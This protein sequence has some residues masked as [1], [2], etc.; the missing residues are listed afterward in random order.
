MD[1]VAVA[2]VNGDV[3]GVARRAPEDQVPGLEGGHGLVGDS[4]VLRFRSPGQ[5]HPR[6]SP[7]PLGQARAVEPVPGVLGP[8]LIG[9]ADL[10]LRRLHRPPGCAVGRGEAGRKTRGCLLLRHELGDLALE[11]M[12]RRL[13]G[14][15]RG[16]SSAAS[17][18]NLVEGGLGLCL[19]GLELRLLRR[20]MLLGGA[21]R[22]DRGGHLAGGEVLV[23]RG[24]SGLFA[25][26]AEDGAE[27][28]VA[29]AGLVIRQGFGSQ[30]GLVR[31]H[32]RLVLDDGRADL[33]DPGLD[34]GQLLL[35]LLVLLGQGVEAGAVGLDLGLDLGRL[36]PRRA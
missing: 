11:R 2:N 1:H 13:L 33:G 24:G 29:G 23:L 3:G 32:L 5:G 20:Q 35:R 12:E 19:A 21:Q 8:P 9:D 10:A 18:S 30:P 27:P 15:G 6:L 14:A 17:R 4:V 28:R 31:R 36:G 22:V 34:G 25:R 26:T 7:G 16:F